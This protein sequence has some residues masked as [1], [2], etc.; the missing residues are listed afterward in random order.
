M[1]AKTVLLK[2]KGRI[3]TI[4]LN[5]PQAMNSMNQELVNDLIEAL[6]I[7]KDDSE[8]RTLIITGSGKGFCAGGDIF[9]LLS[10]TSQIEARKFIRQAGSIISII[11]KMEKPVI[12]MVNGAAAGA[13][14]N[15]AMACDIVICAKSARF[16]QSFAKVGL[17]AD[18][19]GFYLLPRI[20]GPHKAK[21]LM[22]TADTITAD[23]ALSLGIA[24]NVVEDY[25]LGD[26]VYKLANRLSDGA[27]IAIG[28]IKTMV[29]RSNKLDLESTLAYEEDLQCICMQTVDHQEGVEAFKEK[30]S[31]VFRGK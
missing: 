10:I 29:N 16:T 26:T 5:R 3:A 28:I 15:L 23:M 14:F 22:F 6:T 11:M 18:S 12:A 31:P 1:S 4:T 17:V 9:Y 21:E 2:K 8:I 24:N 13:G 27:P 7:A 20:V 25:V 30:R 19:G